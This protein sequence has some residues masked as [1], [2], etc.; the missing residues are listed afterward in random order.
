MSPFRPLIRAVLEASAARLPM[1]SLPA[2]RS[3]PGGRRARPPL[4]CF[5]AMLLAMT[6]CF[7]T[8]PSSAQTSQPDPEALAREAMQK[9]VEK[10][11]REAELKAI[12]QRLAGN[13]DARASLEKE[14]A[15]IRAEDRKSVV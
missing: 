15:S 1:P 6:V 13:A 9:L 8:A 5:V 14:I 2:Q 7:A 3:N 4:D 10:Q 11:A 12:E